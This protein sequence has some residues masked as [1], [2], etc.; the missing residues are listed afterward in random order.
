MWAVLAT[1]AFGMLL[2]Y[3]GSVP[4]CNS[5]LFLDGDCPAKWRHIVAAPINEVGDTLA[6]LAGVLAF[7]WLVAT[8]LLQ[9]HELREQ[10]K[11]FREQREATQDMARAMAAQ[12]KIF[13]DEQRQRKE[14]E[15]DTSVDAL[16]EELHYVIRR[17][18]LEK[19]EWIRP[20]PT[21]S[22]PWKKLP[23]IWIKAYYDEDQSLDERLY[24]QLHSIADNLG[25]IERMCEDGDF[26][27]LPEKSLALV[28]ISKKIAETLELSEGSSAA[29][30]SRV[31][32]ISLG[33]WGSLIEDYLHSKPIWK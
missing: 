14:A 15:V 29:T 10:R 12:E 17:S 23:P 25:K 9:A 11:E 24:S 5:D 6:G 1:A 16:L 8:V 30:K 26:V 7:I 32:K 2:A 3:L 27:E 33:S 13:L 20:K 31:R 18:G 21:T 22:E 28:M 19:P 4:T